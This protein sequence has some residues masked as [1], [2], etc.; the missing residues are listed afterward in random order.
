MDDDTPVDI[1]AVR[2]ERSL[3]RSEAGIGRTMN[4]PGEGWDTRCAR[5]ATRA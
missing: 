2:G 1:H 5:T 4:R 3:D